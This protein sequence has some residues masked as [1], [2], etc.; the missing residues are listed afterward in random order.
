[1]PLSI[2]LKWRLSLSKIIQA[3]YIRISGSNQHTRPKYTA[4]VVIPSQLWCPRASIRTAVLTYDIEQKLVECMILI[5]QDEHR[6]NR[7]ALGLGLF[8]N[9]I[10]SQDET[11]AD[12]AFS[13]AGRTLCTVHRREQS[14]SERVE[15]CTA[16]QLNRF[17]RAD[18]LN[19]LRL[20]LQIQPLNEVDFTRFQGVLYTNRRR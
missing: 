1:M 2:Q 14:P 16:Q 13:R 8:A 12:V 4:I 7:V 18:L 20:C 5:G 19:Q 3:L 6:S 11:D 9:Q 17:D 15:L 10:Q